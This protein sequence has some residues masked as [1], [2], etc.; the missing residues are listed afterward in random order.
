M[1]TNMAKII[2]KIWLTKL[3]TLKSFNMAQ[4]VNY[5]KRCH[6]ILANLFDIFKNK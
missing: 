6:G 3:W 5:G 2:I 1:L 4:S